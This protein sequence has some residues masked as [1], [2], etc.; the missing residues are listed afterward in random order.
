MIAES[1]NAFP[2]VHGDIRRSRVL[3]FPAYS[4]FYRVVREVVVITAV[5]HGRRRPRVWKQRR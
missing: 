3:S 5:F 1:P 2:E 4:V